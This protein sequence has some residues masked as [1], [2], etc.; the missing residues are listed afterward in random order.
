[1]LE[2]TLTII[3][4][5]ALGVVLAGGIWS[6]GLSMLPQ[7]R[8]LLAYPFGLL[9]AVA[10][11]TLLLVSLWFLPVALVFALPLLARGLSRLPRAAFWA[12][13]PAV[14]LGTALGLVN[15]G[16]TD[17]VDSSAY[18]DML[19]YAA[20]VVSAEQSIFPFRDLLVAGERQVYVE[21][22]WMFV[23][24]A[25]ESI[26]GVDPIL[27]Q[28][29]TA[30]AFFLTALAIGFALLRAP[31]AR[32]AALVALL[33]VATIAYP[34]W[35]TESPPVAVAAPLA[36]ALYA[37]WRDRLPLPLL[38]TVGA[39]VGGSFF[40]TKALGLVPLTIVGGV[41]IVRDHRRLAPAL[42]AAAAVAGVAVVALFAADS[43]WLAD[44]LEPKFLPVDAARGLRRQLDVR[45][46]QTAAT[47]VLIVGQLLLAAVLARQRAWTLLAVLTAA[48][49]GG[50]L[51]GGHG[52][53]VVLGIAVL[54]AA[55]L[56]VERGVKE[57]WLVGAAA[58]ALASAA[59]FRDISGVAST[60]L[61]IALIVAG[62][63]L[64]LV[65]RPPLAIA[66]GVAALI[67][68]GLV[69]FPTDRATTL[70]SADRAAWEQMHD[71]VPPDGL[72]FTSETGPVVTGDQGWNY[73]P[74]I[75][76]RQLY[77]AGWSNSPLLVD[78][79]ERARRLELNRR[80]LAGLLDPRE[81]ELDRVYSSYYAVVDR[82]RRVPSGSEL[83]YRNGE[84]ALYELP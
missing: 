77:L 12:A 71:A 82:G 51:V 56:L 24:G 4:H 38:L 48:I 55:C 65:R 47:S 39:A 54:L 2:L 25:L 35:L 46:T 37:I 59:W 7:E 8:A 30:P 79:E 22:A 5:A 20:K 29:A 6:L 10:A 17:R 33:A 21:S 68:I 3:A 64:A 41:A 70:T 45:D 74:G 67:A 1:V 19:F 26:P 81:L 18:G 53:D 40:L 60:L 78:D 9:A 32:S 42:L 72:V 84:L 69:V 13:L 16:P 58:V 76:G 75:W 61:P 80:A 28:A 27:L 23:G 52:F 57:P 62:V 11:A 44:V 43:A 36:F 14:A 83:L 15:H 34:T 31:A 50:W 49:G 73:Y 66:A 63:L